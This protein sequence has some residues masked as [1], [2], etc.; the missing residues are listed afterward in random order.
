MERKGKSTILIVILYLLIAVILALAYISVRKD[1]KF[2]SPK[3]EIEYGVSIV[4]KGVLKPIGANLKGLGTHFLIKDDESTVILDL[5]EIDVG[6][7]EGQKVEVHGI[8]EKG[9][10]EKPILKV[11]DIDFA[12]EEISKPEDS[13]KPSVDW[14]N[15]QSADLGIMFKYKSEWILEPTGRSLTIK[16]PYKDEVKPDEVLNDLIIFE[17]ITNKKLGFE[18]YISSLPDFNSMQKSKIGIDG[19]SAY[20]RII[21]ES[22]KVIFYTSR[23]NKFIYRFSYTPSKL[24]PFDANQNMFYEII[25]TLR[26]IPF[27]VVG[28]LM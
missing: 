26:F 6:K 28:P 4:E 21:S 5:S 1:V 17:L 3:T 23:E 16:I 19:T 25:S 9:V 12:E 27:G 2:F 14:I 8:Y 10:S 20:K 18:E 15:Y 24:K 13:A 22:G 11:R 7:Y